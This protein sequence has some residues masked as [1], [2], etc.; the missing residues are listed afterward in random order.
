MQPG[1]RKRTGGGRHKNKRTENL[2]CIAIAI[3]TR[4]V[5]HF[6]IDPPSVDGALWLQDSEWDPKGTVSLSRARNKLIA[7]TASDRLGF[8]WLLSLLIP[9]ILPSAQSENPSVF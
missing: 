5:D 3:I 9:I 6:I 7:L 2:A 1:V 4:E 8:M